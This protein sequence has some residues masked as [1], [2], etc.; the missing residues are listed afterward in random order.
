MNTWSH[1]LTVCVKTKTKSKVPQ[2]TLKLVSEMQNN[3]VK[4][5]HYVL[6]QLYFLL[7]WKSANCA[8]V[9]AKYK[10]KKVTY[11]PQLLAV[12]GIFTFSKLLQ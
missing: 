6:K 5:E 3:Y 4:P 9:Q 11:Q 10:Y 2:L 1:F 12:I 7:H 8:D